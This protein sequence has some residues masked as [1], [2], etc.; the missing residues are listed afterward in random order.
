MHNVR[1]DKETN[2]P[3][4]IIE[5]KKTYKQKRSIYSRANKIDCFDILEVNKSY[6]KGVKPS[7]SYWFASHA[8]HVGGQEQK[9][10][11][12]LGTKL[13]FHVNSLK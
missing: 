8:S 9:Q 1:K 2:S 13:Y 6:C 4:T 12:P 7:F 11:F 10:F 3:W 5:K